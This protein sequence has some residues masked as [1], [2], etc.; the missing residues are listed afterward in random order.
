[1]TVVNTNIHVGHFYFS[2]SVDEGTGSN[3]LIATV[4]ATDEDTDARGAITYHVTAGDG[5]GIFT[6]GVSNGEIRTSGSP[7]YETKRSYSLVVQAR[8]G[9][10]PKLTSTCRVW[11]AVVDTNDNPPIFQPP[12]YTVDVSEDVAAGAVITTVYATD[13]DSSASGNNAVVYSQTSTVDFNVD[14]ASG[15]LTVNR[16]L[17]RE[18]TAR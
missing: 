1:M 12:A 13:A 6:V 11:I 7:D 10:S 14:S 4:S 15:V 2:T 9:G 8:D 3:T 16:L 5:N 18:A 17:N